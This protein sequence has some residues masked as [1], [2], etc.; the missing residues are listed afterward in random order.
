L[1]KYFIPP[2]GSTNVPVDVQPVI[3]FDQSIDPTSLVYGDARNIVLCQKTSPTSNACIN[4]TI[5]GATVEITSLVYRNDRLIIHP[6][7]PLQPGKLYTLF[8]GNNL[9]PLTECSAYS[10]VISGRV[11][12]NFTTEN[13]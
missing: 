7:Q 12:N 4:S 2:N 1:I 11:Q 3:I 5:I 13:H 6:L 9:K 8:V 10:T